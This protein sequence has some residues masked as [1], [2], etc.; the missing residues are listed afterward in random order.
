MAQQESAGVSSRG[1]EGEEC[2]SQGKLGV[3]GY[4]AQNARGRWVGVEVCGVL[5]CI[6]W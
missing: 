4:V 2:R 5:V 1:E 3:E 6:A